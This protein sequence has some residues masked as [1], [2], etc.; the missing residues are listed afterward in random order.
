MTVEPK[1]EH[2]K[3][4][5]IT[6]TVP[7]NP[8]CR[9]VLVTCVSGPRA[10][11]G[12]E[13]ARQHTVSPCSPC[14]RSDKA[15]CLKAS[16]LEAYAVVT[17]DNFVVPDLRTHLPCWQAMP[18]LH[19]HSRHCQSTLRHLTN[20]HMTSGL[21]SC[22][23]Y[24]LIYLPSPIAG[25]SLA[26]LGSACAGNNNQLARTAIPHKL[27]TSAVCQ[28]ALL[29]MPGKLQLQPFSLSTIPFIPW[30]RKLG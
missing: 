13:L 28:L 14:C 17:L 25:L 12:T 4:P 5:P 19:P 15:T 8:A 30:H 27:P 9:P 21:L 22:R 2:C 24:R 16:T 10:Q 6:C 11:G 3:P 26:L 23:A 29:Q 1:R 18:V 7:L 20:N